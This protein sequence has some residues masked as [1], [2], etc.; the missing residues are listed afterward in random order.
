VIADLDDFKQ[1]NDRYG[2]QAGD[3]VLRAVAEVLGGSLRELDLAA[4]FGGEEFALIL[5]G[6]TS[7]GA[8]RVADQVRELLARAVVAGPDGKPIRVTASFGVA[9]F[10]SCNG[11]DELVAGA[12]AALYAAKRAGKN[13]VV[14]GDDD[15]ETGSVAAIKTA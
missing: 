13:R 8:R 9:E 10:P 14:T 6:T 3:E 4:R 15:P 5:P 7:S 2:H 12:D 11:V 1:V